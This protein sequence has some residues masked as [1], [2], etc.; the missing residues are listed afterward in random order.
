MQPLT[1]A[2]ILNVDVVLLLFEYASLVPTHSSHLVVKQLFNVYH[3]HNPKW[4]GTGKESQG[5]SNILHSRRLWNK[6]V[7]SGRVLCLRLSHTNILI[8]AVADYEFRE[9][10]TPRLR[11]FRWDSEANLSRLLDDPFQATRVQQ[12]LFLRFTLQLNNVSRTRNPLTLTT[13]KKPSCS[14]W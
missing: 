7:I 5:S 1:C 14:N 12:L 9:K 6:L 11:K 10:F 4:L 8:S 2:A 13:I 3:S